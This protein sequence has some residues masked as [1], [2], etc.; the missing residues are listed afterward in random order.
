MV[1]LLTGDLDKDHY[2]LKENS[3]KNDNSK[4]YVGDYDKKM[5]LKNDWRLPGKYDF[6]I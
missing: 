5:K 2:K 6:R 4:C 1:D 3:N